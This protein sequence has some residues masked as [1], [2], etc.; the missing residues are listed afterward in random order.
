[1]VNSDLEIHW[2]E[3]PASRPKRGLEITFWLWKPTCNG[4]IA[5]YA[6]LAWLP[7]GLLWWGVESTLLQILWFRLYCHSTSRPTSIPWVK[8]DPCLHWETSHCSLRWE[9]QCQWQLLLSDLGSV[10]CQKV[11]PLKQQWQN[12]PSTVSHQFVKIHASF[13]TEHWI[14]VWRVG[15]LLPTSTVFKTPVSKTGIL[16]CGSSYSLAKLQSQDC[17]SW[18]RF[19]ANAKCV[20]AW[21]CHVS[22]HS[23]WRTVEEMRQILTVKCWS[24]NS[25]IMSA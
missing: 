15:A 24:I 2:A 17:A 11:S 19:V 7:P 3:L 14:Q 8:L 16:A 21:F 5:V 22:C 10:L 23:A 1:M 25:V 18:Y 12:Q 13:G 9:Q 20:P 6:Q 4:E